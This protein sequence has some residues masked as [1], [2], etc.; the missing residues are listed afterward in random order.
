[1]LPA[2]ILGRPV[3]DV[4]ADDPDD[5]DPERGRVDDAADRRRRLEERAHL[6]PCDEDD[7]EQPLEHGR[8][9]ADEIRQRPLR[10]DDEVADEQ[11]HR[12]DRDAADQVSRREL[13]VSL[14]R[15]RDR[16]RELR[17]A[18]RRSRAGSVRRSRR[19][20]RAARRARPS[21]SRARCRPPT[22]RRRRRGRSGGGGASRARPRR[23]DAGGGGRSK[24]PAA[25]LSTELLS[26]RGAGRL[27]ASPARLRRRAPPG[28][29]P[30][31]NGVS[32]RERRGADA[33]LERCALADQRSR[34]HLGDL[35]AVDL[36][37]EHAVEDEVERVA[38]LAPC[39]TSTAPSPSLRR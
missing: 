24:P 3:D 31:G 30:R 8:Q 29:R 35:L 10:P 27:R 2:R 37:R 33:A 18:S 4:E 9:P 32:A 20:D 36:D 38:S 21:S 19:R 16:D 14:R 7:H 26:P 12:L 5:D 23:N 15:R 11:H 39:V 34:P 6:D 13:E 17:Q 25:A 22:S 28:S 1:M